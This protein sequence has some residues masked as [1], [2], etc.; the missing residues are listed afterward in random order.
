MVTPV[1]K[2]ASAEARKQM[3]RAWS[4][5][6]ATRPSGVRPISAARPSA[7]RRS[8]CGRMR[9]ESV[10]L[11]AIALTVMPWGPS[12]NASLRV[13]AMMPPFAVA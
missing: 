1:T 4:S 10:R 13:R 7:V 12:S 3:T 9:S 8:Q 6:V 2:S 5:G 11:G